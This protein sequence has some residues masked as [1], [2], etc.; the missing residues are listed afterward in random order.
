[1]QISRTVGVHVISDPTEISQLQKQ[2]SLFLAAITQ[3]LLP[4]RDPLGSLLEG[5]SLIPNEVDLLPVK[6]LLSEE[7]N[8]IQLLG[9]Y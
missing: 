7:A 1:M 8:H 3:S 9:S 2:H 4:P 6:Q 5:D